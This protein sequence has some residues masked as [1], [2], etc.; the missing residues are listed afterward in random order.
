MSKLKAGEVA[1]WATER[2]IQILGGNGYTREYPV[3]RWHRDAKIYTIFEGTSEIQRLVIAARSRGSRS[4]SNRWS[5]FGRCGSRLALPSA[6]WANGWLGPN[7]GRVFVVFALALVAA[8]GRRATRRRWGCRRLLDGR[9]GRRGSTAR[10][11]SPTPPTGACSS[12]RRPGGCASWARTGTC[13][14]TP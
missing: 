14:P 10:P 4:R 13:G 8:V 7:C 3:E 1:V 2:A 5:R 9:A 11:R 6:S 12:R